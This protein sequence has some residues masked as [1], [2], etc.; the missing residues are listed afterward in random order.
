MNNV[1]TPD[2]LGLV[3]AAMN[4]IEKLQKDREAL[5]I[6]T[7]KLEQ[8]VF[9]TSNF[10]SD[11]HRHLVTERMRLFQDLTRVR[12]AG[13]TDAIRAVLTAEGDWLSTTQVRDRLISLQ[14]DFSS[15]T[16]NPL[17]SVSTTL[18]RM[19]PED[20]EIGTRDGV[21]AY[22]WK[23]RSQLKFSPEFLKT[24]MKAIQKNKK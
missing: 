20:V 4:K 9:A 19:K 5:H 13:L 16:T 18:K 11:E 15:Y 24:A 1:E 8:F 7:A 14:Y 21:A 22:R 10:L 6:E 23:N 3:I 2:Y 17:A 12:D